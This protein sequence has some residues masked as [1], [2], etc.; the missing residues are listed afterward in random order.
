MTVCP[1]ASVYRRAFAVLSASMALT[2]I[3]AFAGRADAGLFVSVTDDQRVTLLGEHASLE[4][5]MEDLSWRAGFELRSFG[6]DDRSVTA[7]IEDVPLD[8]AL[9]RLVGR[10]LYT[11]G[12]SVGEDG[13]ARVMWVEIPGPREPMGARRGIAKPRGPGEAPFQVP[14]KLFLAAF[15]SGD[16]SERTEAFASIQERVLADPA[17]RAR[18]LATDVAMFV[19]AVAKYPDAAE[20]F[21]QLAGGQQ[22]PALRAKLDSVIAAI[23]AS[24]ASAAPLP[25]N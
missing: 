17:E 11:V 20:T 25:A 14:P 10:D 12:L 3:F 7:R 23:E 22:D 16:P 8:D 18:F 1:I 19:E 6:L 4:G 15:E 5:L 21:R 2:A 9:H 13:K 24:R